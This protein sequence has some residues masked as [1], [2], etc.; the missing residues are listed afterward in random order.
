MI[1]SFG[2]NAS[3]DRPVMT[4]SGAADLPVGNVTRPNGDGCGWN[5]DPP[6]GE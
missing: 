4:D 5:E 3:G 2:W 6:G 1:I